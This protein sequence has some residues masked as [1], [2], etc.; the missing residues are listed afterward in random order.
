LLQQNELRAM[1]SDLLLLLLLGWLVGWQNINR[2]DERNGGQQNCTKG[3]QSLYNETKLN[4][5]C[6][7]LLCVNV[8]SLGI[9]N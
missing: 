8:F 7:S 5:A 6:L 3:M 9:L 2:D 1:M 4:T